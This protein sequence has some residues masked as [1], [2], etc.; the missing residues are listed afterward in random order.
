MVTVPLEI[1]QRGMCA[2]IIPG[3]LHSGRSAYTEQTASAAARDP[4]TPGQDR[5]RTRRSAVSIRSTLL[6]SLIGYG[7]VMTPLGGGGGLP[8]LWRLLFEVTCPGCGLSR[9]NALL[10]RGFFHESIAM[11]VLI[12]PLWLVAIWSF[13][14][15][16]LTFTREVHHG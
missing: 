6:P 8:C 15:T 14:A 11:N 5:E 12:I 16:F 1:V 4:P 7:L 2:R 9:A 13:A 3:L 10:V